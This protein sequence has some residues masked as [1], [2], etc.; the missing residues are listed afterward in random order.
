MKNILVSVT[1]GCL[2]AI[3]TG[4][5]TKGYVRKEMQPTVNKI[6]ELDELTAKNTNNMRDVD[7]RAQAGI[8]GVNQKAQAADQKAQV[9]GQRAT[10]AQNLAANAASQAEKLG[11]VVANLDT[12][13]PVA[14]A[15]VHFGFDKAELSA[16]AKD[17]LDQLAAEIPNTKGYIIELEG[18]TDSVGDKAYNY[19]LSKRRAAAVTQYLASKFD[20]PAH[21]I[22]VIGLGEDR[23]AEENNSSQGRA[24][25]RR[26]DVKLMSNTAQPAQSAAASPSNR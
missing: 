26:V 3:T 23:A 16:K 15:S 24:A 12:Y 6:N 5:A 8:S 14:E 4:C 11:T 17:A 13:K 10:D 20:V 1:A 18:G 7:A 25:N 2:M 19:E 21:K 9:A 22:Y